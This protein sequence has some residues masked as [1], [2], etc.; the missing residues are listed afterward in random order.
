MSRIVETII[1][2]RVKP[3]TTTGEF[4]FLFRWN[5]LRHD[6]SCSVDRSGAIVIC[7][8]PRTKGVVKCFYLVDLGRRSLLH[9]GPSKVINKDSKGL[10]RRREVVDKD[11]V[12][13]KVFIPSNGILCDYFPLRVFRQW[14]FSVS[15]SN[16]DPRIEFGQSPKSIS[17]T[18]IPCRVTEL[19]CLK[20]VF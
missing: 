4:P 14:L 7:S 16:F 3:T 8:S 11:L 13:P 2:G 12:V 19:E 1:F 5:K 10:K 9:E 18:F 17:F 6:T 15:L 20:V